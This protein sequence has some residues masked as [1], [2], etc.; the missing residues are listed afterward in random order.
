MDLR[1]KDRRVDWLGAFLVTAGLAMLLFV[2]GDGT[3]AVDAWET[4]CA[5]AVR[6]N[7]TC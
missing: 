1:D 6:W 3:V 2:L 4:S 7:H 5:C